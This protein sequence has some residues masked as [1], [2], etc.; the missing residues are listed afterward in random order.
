MVPSFNLSNALPKTS[1]ANENTINILEE[2]QVRT[3]EERKVKNYS[4][5]HP[6]QLQRE[7]ERETSRGDFIWFKIWFY[8]NYF[9]AESSL[10]VGCGLALLWPA[11]SAP[12]SAALCCCVMCDVLA[13]PR[14]PSLHPSSFIF[15]EWNSKYSL[16]CTYP[17][18][19]DGFLYLKS[20]HRYTGY[21]IQNDHLSFI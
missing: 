10:D 19:T 2:S 3:T 9:T 11:V 21:R 12:L 14:H 8:F 17:V 20:I 16:L 1:V 15:S 6:P 13:A 18:P 7:R 5:P 4:T